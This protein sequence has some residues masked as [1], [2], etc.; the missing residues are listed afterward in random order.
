[1]LKNQYAILLFAISCLIFAADVHTKD[2]HVLN[3]PYSVE[4]TGSFHASYVG[5]DSGVSV[6]D[7]SGDF[8]KYISGQLNVDAR[9]VVATE[10][11]QNIEPDHHFLVFFT[12][13]AVDTADSTAFA[14][15]YQNTVEGI[16]KPIFNNSAAMGSDQL[17]TT[18]DMADVHRWEM[19]PALPR[20]DST[21]D[22]LVH[23]MMHQWGINVRFMNAQGQTSTDLLGR[24]G[25]HWNYFMHSNASVMYGAAWD[26]LNSNLF[27]TADRMRSLSPLDLYLMGMVQSSAVPDFFYIDSGAPG[28]VNDIP[29]IVGTEVTGNRINVSIQD[30]IAAEG[31]RIPSSDQSPHQFN[32]KFVLLKRPLEQL[33]AELTGQLLVLQREFQKRFA[34]ETGGKGAILYPQL[35]THPGPA[36]PESLNYELTTEDQIDLPLAIAF[37]AS[38]AELNGWADKP[39]TRTRDTALAVRALN[40]LGEIGLIAN[41]TNWLE[42]HTPVSNDELAWQLMS[43]VLSAGKQQSVV[44]QLLSNI[45]EDGGWGIKAGTESSVVDTLLV[46]KALKGALGAAYEPGSETLAFIA[47]Q[48][49]TD[50]A[51]G[52]AVG[53]ESTLIAS[54]LLLEMYYALTGDAIT[55]SEI[56]NQLINQQLPDGG[57]GHGVASVHHTAQA[58]AA[59]EAANDQSHSIVIDNARLKLS[60]MQSTDGSFE[61]SVYST[62]LAV[63]M[64]F[65]D[66]RPNISLV[67]LSTTA[68]TVVA[69]EELVLEVSLANAGADMAQGFS[70]EVWIDQATHSTVALDALAAGESVTAQLM[71]DTVTLT[72]DVILNVVADPGDLIVESNEADNNSS[73]SVQV[74]A[75]TQVPELAFLISQSSYRPDFVDRLPITF[76]AE[77]M[78]GNHSSSAV[79]DVVLGLYQQQADGSFTELDSI[80]AD[81][82]QSST[83]AFNFSTQITDAPNNT[84]LVL[85]WVIDPQNQIQEVNES[86]NQWQVILPQVPTVDLNLE[87]ADV[88]MPM[89]FVVGDQVEISFD[90]RNLGSVLSSGFSLKAELTDGQSTV[91]LYD[92]QILEMAGGQ[93]FTRQFNWI[94]D[95]PG[96][97]ELII[98][99]DDSDQVAEVD[100]TNNSVSL[101][102]TVVANTYSNLSISD[103]DVSI[104]PDPGLVGQL[105]TVSARVSNPSDQD[106][107]PYQLEFLQ[108]IEDNTTSLAVV[109]VPS[110][111]AGSDEVVNLDLPGYTGLG[112]VTF[113]V[114]ADPANLI[115]EFNEN[116]NIG[117]NTFRIL[118][119][120]DAMVSSGGFALQPTIPVIGEQLSVDV[121]VVN[122]GEQPLDD[123]S[124][125]LYTISNGVETEVAELTIPLIEAGQSQV[126]Q[127]S[128]V[129]PND[130]DLTALKVTTDGDD[131]IIEISE[132]NNEAVLQIENQSKVFYV[133]ETYFSPNGDGVK[134][135]TSIVFNLDETDDYQISIIDQFNETI[136]TFPLQSATQ[137]GDLIW[138]G[139]NDLNRL[140]LDGQ[141][142]VT[143]TGQN[144][145]TSHQ[146]SVWLDTNRT[147]LHESLIKND[148][149]V[150]D[151]ECAL[152]SVGIEG[153]VFFNLQYSAD[154]QSIYLKD[155]DYGDRKGKLYEVGADG[156]SAQLLTPPTFNDDRRVVD[157]H[158]LD[159]GHIIIDARVNIS[160][161]NE[162]WFLDP[163]SK[164]F[165]QLDTQ[166][167]FSFNIPIITNEYSVITT[168][169]NQFLKIFHDLSPGVSFSSINPFGS[170]LTQVKSGWLDRDEFD[171]FWFQDG[172]L[173]NSPV[174]LGERL[175]ARSNDSSRALMFSDG[176]MVLFQFAGGQVTEVNDIFESV[177]PG[178]NMAGY[179]SPFNQFISVHNDQ[180]SMFD[181]NG[182]K[183]FDIANPYGL[184]FLQSW[185]IE[186]YG[187]LDDIVVF[188]EIGE[189]TVSYN[190]LENIKPQFSRFNANWLSKTE[191]LLSF[192]VSYSASID[193]SLVGGMF[194]EFEFEGSWQY[195]RKINHTDISDVGF[196]ETN[197]SSID[198]NELDSHYYYSEQELLLKDQAYDA[199]E[200]N[201]QLFSDFE[202]IQAYPRNLYPGKVSSLLLATENENYRAECRDLNDNMVLST[203]FPKDN[204]FTQLIIEHTQ[205]GLAINGTVFDANLDHFQ[206]YY[207]ESIDPENWLL[208][209]GGSEE[210]FNQLLMNWNPPVSGTYRVKL[211][212]TDKAGNRTSVIKQTAVSRTQSIISVPTVDP[213]YISPNG[214]GIKEHTVIEYQSLLAG[215]VL[216]EVTNSAGAVV[217][218]WI[219]EYA[220]SGQ[221]EQLVWTGTDDNAQ[222]L[223]D[224][225]YLVSVNGYR[226]SVMIDTRPPVGSTQ[227]VRSPVYHLSEN[228]TLV[229]SEG[230]LSYIDELRGLPLDFDGFNDGSPLALFEPQKQSLAEWRAMG[231]YRFNISFDDYFDSRGVYRWQLTDS[232]GNTGFS[233]EVTELKKIFFSE[234]RKVDLR[235]AEPEV[236]YAPLHYWVLEERKAEK[237]SLDKEDDKPITDWSFGDKLSLVWQSFSDETV[238]SV[239]LIID[240]SDLNGDAISSERIIELADLATAQTYFTDDLISPDNFPIGSFGRPSLG[241]ELVLYLVEM[242][243]SW[244]EGFVGGISV[245]LEVEFAGTENSASESFSISFIESPPIP[246]FTRLPVPILA[247]ETWPES[248]REYYREVIE[249]LDLNNGR[250]YTLLHIPQ[251]LLTNG[252]RVDVYSYP[253]DEFLHS[254]SPFR[255]DSGEHISHI[256]ELDLECNEKVTAI[257]RAADSSVNELET[258]LENN[259]IFVSQQRFD[260]GAMCDRNQA[261]SDAVWV[262]L[263]VA[264]SNDPTQDPVSLKLYQYNNNTEPVLIYEEP[265][266]S[267]NFKVN[268]YGLRYYDSDIHISKQLFDA[269]IN[270]VFAEVDYLFDRTYSFSVPFDVSFQG[271]DFDIISPQSDVNYCGSTRELNSGST[272]TDV[273]LDLGLVINNPGQTGIFALNLRRFI[274]GV[275][276]DQE[277]MDSGL[278]DGPP[279][280]GQINSQ[281]MTLLY[282][283]SNDIKL[284]PFGGTFGFDPPQHQQHIELNLTSIEGPA[285]I[286]I[287]AINSSG[288][289]V[290]ESVQINIDTL[291]NVAVADQGINDYSPAVSGSVVFAEIEAYEDADIEIMLSDSQSLIKVMDQYSLSQ[292]QQAIVSWDGIVAG[293]IVEDGEY[294]IVVRS[295]DACGNYKLDRI[296][297]TVDTTPPA[298]GFLNLAD[299]QSIQVLQDV[300]VYLDELNVD[301]FEV[302][303]QYLDFWTQFEMGEVFNNGLGYQEFLT[304]WDLSGLPIGAYP[305]RI[306]ARDQ[307]G[308]E[309]ELQITLVLNEAQNLLWEFDVS[310]RLI[311]PNGDGIKDTTQ[312]SLGLNLNA[313]VEVLMVDENQAQV[314]E[315]FS[316]VLQDGLHEWTWDGKDQLSTTVQDGQYQLNVTITE[317]GN[318]SNSTTVESLL[319]VDA[320]APVISINPIEPVIKG[321]GQ[322]TIVIDDEH[323][324]EHSSQLHV[325]DS[326]ELPQPIPS[327]TDPGIHHQ[328]ALSDL[329][330][331]AYEVRTLA[332]DLAGNIIEHLH[333]LTID[334]TPP[335]LVLTEPGQD[336]VIGGLHSEFLISGTVNE[337]HFAQYQILIS[338]DVEPPVWQELATD[339]Q[340]DDG[341]FSWPWIFN[342]ADGSYLLKVIVTD[343]AGW[344]AE[345]INAFTLDR[346]PPVVALTSPADQLQVGEQLV[347][348]GTVDDMSLV[349][350][351]ISH[352]TLGSTE[353]TAIRSG[354]EPIINDEIF[355][356]DHQLSSGDHEFRILANDAAGLSTEIIQSFSVD[357]TPPGAPQNLVVELLMNR[358]AQLNWQPVDAVDLAGYQVFRNNT[359]LNEQ[360]LLNPQLTDSDLPEGQYSY[361]VVA[362]DDIGNH[363]VP[364]NVQ[365]II[366]DRTAPLTSIQTPADQSLVNGSVDIIGS[367]E[368][369]DDLAS[370]ELFIRSVSEPAPGQLLYTST[371]PVTAQLMSQLDTSSLIQDESYVILLRSTDLLNNI[372]ITEHTVTV[373]N[374]PPTAPINLV[375]TIQ[376]QADVRLDWQ[377]NQEADLSGYLVFRNG[378]IVSGNGTPESGQVTDVFYLDPAVA[379]G[380]YIYQVAAIDLA[381]NISA[382]SQQVE[383]VIS[384]RAPD[385]GIS[386]PSDG[387]RFGDVV[388]IQATSPDQDLAHIWIEYSINH[389][390]WFTISLD[391]V[392]PY[393]VVFSPNDFGLGYGT[394]AI[395]AT[396]E[397]TAAQADQTPAQINVEYTDVTSPEPLDNIMA[398]SAGSTVNL[399]W[400]ASNAADLLGYQVFRRQL[401]PVE[402]TDFVLLHV[403]LLTT[404][405]YLD[406]GLEVGLY[407]YQVLAVDDYDNA[408][409]PGYSNEAPVMAISLHQPYS[410]VLTPVELVFTGQSEYSGVIQSELSNASGDLPLTDVSV[411]LSGQFNVSTN[412]WQAGLNNLSAELVDADGHISLVA[413]AAIEVSEVPQIPDNPLSSVNGLELTL[414]WDAPTPDT[415]GYLLHLNN[416]P[417]TPAERVISYSTAAASS[418]EFSADYVFD[419][420]DTSVWSPYFDDVNDGNPSYLE[421][422]FDQP[423]W[424]LS[425]AFHWDEDYLFEGDVS[426]PSTYQLQYL[427]AIGWITQQDFTGNNNA[428]VTYVGDVPYLAYGVRLWMPLAANNFD[429][430]RL[431][432]WDIQHQPLVSTNTYVDN[433]SDGV[434]EWQV[435]AINSLGFASEFTALEQISLGDT[436]RPEPVQLTAQLGQ[437]VDADLSWTASSSLDVAN[438]RVFRNGALILST[439]DANTLS[440][441]DPAL[442]NGTYDYH[443]IAVD[444]V[445]NQSLSSNTEQV[446]VDQ[447]LLPAPGGLMLQRVNTGGALALSW[448]AYVHPEF[449][450]FRLYRSTQ[451]QTGYAL[452]TETTQL[453]FTD[454]GLDNGTTYHYYLVVIDPRGNESHPS[455]TVFGTPVDLV[456]P[457]QPVIKEPTVA[458]IPI[459]VQ[460][461]ITQIQGEGEPGLAI[462]LFH[463]QDFVET[464]YASDQY[465]LS[466][467]DL[468]IYL[469]QPQLNSANTLFAIMDYNIGYPAILNAETGARTDIE[470]FDVSRYFWSHDGETLYFVVGYGS[471]TAIQAFDQSGNMLSTLF[472]GYSID[473]LAISPDNRHLLY[474]GDGLNP[475]NSQVE[476]GVWLYDT[477]NQTHEK[478]EVNTSTE[479]NSEAIEWLSD[480]LVA[481][482]NYPNGSYD[483]GNLWTYELSTG[484][485]TQLDSST[486]PYGT[487]T[488]LRDGSHLYYEVDV[489]GYV[490]IK[491]LNRS[492]LSV[493]TMGLTNDELMMPTVSDDAN[494]V[495]ANLGCCDKVMLDLQSSEVLF[496]WPN[497]GYQAPSEWLND[498]RILFVENETGFLINGP[499]SFVFE[500]VELT[501]GLNEFFVVARKPNGL[502]TASDEIQVTL[503]TLSLPDLVIKDSYLQVLPDEVLSGQ[504]VSGSL[505][506]KNISSVDVDDARLLI[507]ITD[508][509]LNT[510][511]VSPA[512]LNIGLMAG[513]SFVTDFTIADL[514]EVGEYVIKSTIDSNGAVLES[515]ENNNSTYRLLQVIDDLKPDVTVVVNSHELFPGDQ[516][517][518]LITVY[519]PGAEFTGILELEITDQAGF[520]TGYYET[521]DL[522]AL[523]SG[524]HWNVTFDWPADVF[525]D[526]YQLHVTL[527]EGNSVVDAELIDLVVR[528]A[529]DFLLSLEASLNQALPGDRIILNA[530]LE[531]F[532]G[533]SIQDGT[534]LWQVMD[535]QD[536]VIWQHSEQIDG[537]APGLNIQLNQIWLA[538]DPGSYTAVLTWDNLLSFESV[539]LPLEVLN[540]VS[541]ARIQ[542]Q[543]SA[544]PTPVTLGQDFTTTA[545]LENTGQ[546]DLNQLNIEAR[547]MTQDLSAVLLTDQMSVSLPTGQTSQVQFNWSSDSLTLDHYI[548]VLSV[549]LSGFGESTQSTLDTLLIE[550][551]DASGPIITI[552]NPLHGGLYP[553]DTALITTVTDQHA[554]VN[555]VS[556]L[557][558][559]QLFADL[560][561]N[562]LSQVYQT[563]LSGLSEGVHLL[564]VRAQDEYGNASSTSIDF[565]VD[566]TP[567]LIQ[568]DGVQ[569]GGLYNHS[570]TPIITITD[571]NL[572]STTLMMNGLP[573]QSGQSLSA[574]GSYLLMVSATDLTGNQI[575]QR[576]SFNLDLTPPLLNISFPAEGSDTNLA[577]TSVTGQTEADVMVQLQAGTH[578]Q[579]VQAA[580]DGSYVFTDVPL[581][582]GANVLTL[583]AT[584]QAGNN[585]AEA[586]RTVNYIDAVSVTGSLTNADSHPIGQI[587]TIDWQVNNPYGFAIDQLAVELRLVRV[588]DDVVSYTRSQLIDLPAN[589]VFND[590]DNIQT[591]DLLPGAYQ[592][593]LRV[594]V[595]QTEELIGNS[596]IQLED[597]TGPLLQVLTPQDGAV[598]AAELLLSATASD[599]SSEVLD[600]SYQ[601]DGVG[602]WVSMNLLGIEYT[603]D[604]SL[605]H[606]Q[607]AIQFRAEDSF[608]NQTFSAVINVTIDDQPPLITVNSPA[609]GL[610]TN[611]DVSIDYVMVDDLG[612]TD[613][614]VLNGLPVTS[615][616]VVSDEGDHVLTVRGT[617]DVGNQA[618]HVVQF[619]IDLTPPDLLVDSPVNNQQVFDPLID[620]TGSAEPRNQI[621]T[622]VNGQTGSVNTDAAGQFVSANHT[623][624][625]GLNNITVQAEDEAGNLSQLVV[626]V[627]EYVPVGQVDGSIWHDLNQNGLF[628]AGESGIELAEVTLTDSQQASQVVYTNAS[629]LFSYADVQPGTYTI[630]V[631]D[632]ELNTDWISSTMNS[633]SAITVTAGQTESIEFGYYQQAPV[634]DTALTAHDQDGR[635]L[636]LADEPMAQLDG[637]CQGVTSFKMMRH[638]N[639]LWQPGDQLIVELYDAQSNLIQ[640][641]SG[642]YADFLAN[643]Q[644]AIDAQ[645]AVSLVNLILHPMNSGQISAT[646]VGDDEQA[647]DLLNDDYQLLMK[648]QT[649]SGLHQWSSNVLITNCALF[650]VIGQDMG[651]LKVANVDL[652]PAISSDEPGDVTSPVLLA[653]YTQL[654]GLLD[655]AGWSYELVY[656]EAD[657]D[658]AMLTGMFNTY[659]LMAE[660]VPLGN[661]IQNQLIN[662]LRA[663]SG[664]IVSSGVDNL[665]PG[666]YSELGISVN[667]LYVNVEGLQLLNSELAAATTTELDPQD[668]ALRVTSMGAASA[669]ILLGS[670]IVN[671][672]DQAVTWTQAVNGLAV[673]AAFDWLLQA[674]VEPDANHFAALINQVVRF[675]QPWGLSTELGGTRRVRYSLFNQGRAVDGHVRVT[676]PPSVQLMHATVPTTQETDGFSFNYQ[677]TEQARLDFE[678]WLQVSDSPVDVTFEVYAQGLPDIV[679]SQ[680]MTLIA[681]QK[682]DLTAEISNCQGLVKP[683]ADMSYQLTIQN[684]GNVDISQASAIT[685]FN[686]VSALTWTCES[687]D[688]AHC[689]SA[690]GTGDLAGELIDL[691]VGST[692]TY[693]LSG[694]VND[695]TGQSA[696]ASAV[697]SMPAEWGDVTPENNTASDWDEILPFLFNDGFECVAPTNGQQ[698][699][700]MIREIL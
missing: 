282:N 32:F 390:D 138:D 517:Y 301:V 60:G 206:L 452:V 171:E 273:H 580:A 161:L 557:L 377:A 207:A 610:I 361:W 290:C 570:V 559:G 427:S 297:F 326:G 324:A 611:Q 29:S 662:E 279:E 623:L 7:F 630:A 668:S 330:E 333:N 472:S 200:S 42:Q 652:Y 393:E 250:I 212:A 255:D 463:N 8:D 594:T 221:V 505:L 349:H 172:Q 329:A 85:K 247:Q 211:V 128:F 179:F 30:I 565:T 496:S 639:H 91:V 263:R 395:R 28:D 344:Q 264:L 616:A 274:N 229:G 103:E 311:S 126:A 144:S 469:E 528:E 258:R 145:G 48:I 339:S 650:N 376:N 95:Q 213:I 537:L 52:Y 378:V 369:T 93:T 577:S 654:R 363:S 460:Q 612:V 5:E 532:W 380:T 626:L 185:V 18:I 54:A 515:N 308:N 16:G 277:M 44:D 223:P 398:Q 453:N 232:A 646:V 406:Q 520:P 243:K 503:D 64:L 478:V 661:S 182:I 114:Q 268:E 388:R 149:F 619:R 94:P 487:L 267:I 534:L 384:R 266:M 286:E 470:L 414:N 317:S 510:T 649:S 643:G 483:Y 291:V 462:D 298:V 57:F 525:A 321:E 186:T 183:L 189:F 682:P 334:N 360:L 40:N 102:F 325:P 484:Q 479:L 524:A 355:I 423:Q 254:L 261:N 399:S 447:Q 555:S 20:F 556:V 122:L 696:Q 631:T 521:H 350:Y 288:V 647:N 690:S 475:D 680:S 31:I 55:E 562:T 614:S 660:Q 468:G 609:D 271:V 465:V 436:T 111:A 422:T 199:V 615:G 168:S 602:G 238:T 415:F 490:A 76:E 262:N 215:E 605:P 113:I 698:V 648:L 62:A 148:G 280:Y 155:K 112:D 590:V 45:N 140:A 480:D 92:H 457:A 245:G 370:L 340:L 538:A 190:D 595:D 455:V 302:S 519:N 165:Y 63:L 685:G 150:I 295:E 622:V 210:R 226:Y 184:D 441:V 242:D 158:V 634:I 433:L 36:H 608:A 312:I 289:S 535:D 389:T 37:L 405:D 61:G 347:F 482:I 382:M 318:N 11:Y 6:I 167:E 336:A 527:R 672:E 573:Y 176:S 597:V 12:T 687:L 497:I 683:G 23:E 392:A 118:N 260:L 656:S 435:A 416:Q 637:Q 135:N 348:A 177:N 218:S 458:G 394:I 69:G 421:F 9:Q 310:E 471:D 374:V 120:P 371:I 46:L 335:L 539:Q 65:E 328:L 203:Y 142:L 391:T 101:P 305:V 89:Q 134:D 664:L 362:V 99:L 621:N 568:I 214:D 466:Q 584:D 569:D 191:L 403:D 493:V 283:D 606:G 14:I 77:V 400:Q 22:T 424:I 500:Q 501:P 431:R 691:P 667:G 96:N 270:Q 459:H 492:D 74:N 561:G 256:Y 121:S 59:L 175:I 430:I 695:A 323:L 599:H 477:D 563:P 163:D 174:R 130:P 485:L 464:V 530:G 320:T 294:A 314:T 259:C 379:D 84:D 241:Q 410:P 139:R 418:D 1:M 354:F 699:N 216:I 230:L 408:S 402:E 432:E 551:Q 237:K 426:M 439:S 564:E 235:H 476:F 671:G 548:L 511:M 450:A 234:L 72:G 83:F 604:I 132:L 625:P 445:G 669:A 442:P 131:Q 316:G 542:G 4:G 364:S 598:S 225:E 516:L 108:Q 292:G 100:E 401:L 227:L 147:T 252:S 579:L 473:E 244:F 367:V 489:D 151:L 502:E 543:W 697:I 675:V 345:Q 309:S 409:E 375:Y 620:I 202:L 181:S 231:S 507:E 281:R 319:K 240:G 236:V 617:D 43:D 456:P 197:Y 663:G 110:L 285:T 2:F 467:T 187:S 98:S 651:E 341:A 437:G 228:S 582:E 677:L 545:V 589:G 19:N 332:G 201:N 115:A 107:G 180:L 34:A 164:V 300:L 451:A 659:W 166:G 220:Q 684:T 558:D 434:Y 509:Q 583:Q 653:Q 353:W 39:A 518:G 636:I 284:S 686:N 49:N 13:F 444:Q 10:L 603:A 491:R 429:E 79:T 194:E 253:G 159:N 239:K 413:Q 78:I 665:I 420:D 670:E 296:N 673:F 116:D 26:Q 90:F 522:I 692:V 443:V 571:A 461:S 618:E 249:H 425:S 35:T 547:L 693:Q 446:V 188:T 448:D 153:Q 560:P 657:F 313:Q 162:L 552:Q 337:L 141:Y 546:V 293:Q 481:F 387:H 645:P 251:R 513:E 566:S 169:G 486:A 655:Q 275:D 233:N 540:P 97:F 428:V 156:Q 224:G 526:Q 327:A 488:A 372:H 170:S 531:Y 381:G 198:L 119:L 385:T 383:V 299:G 596:A 591:D 508:P 351:Q 278:F 88:V 125:T 601:L 307:F 575:Q 499:G 219:R 638:T 592:A 152:Q 265:N 357:A 633:P 75:Q 193:P 504:P 27:E 541:Q 624:Q 157:Y 641:E 343:E 494:L 678:F 3:T 407:Q 365:T 600:V 635:I 495:F 38:N 50:S 689:A 366:V 593:H 47:Q 658:A 694:V 58:L 209:G 106:S 15:S 146:T 25:V 137:F 257:W 82:N 196:Y 572:A 536:Q 192:D 676:L 411:D 105:L 117:F 104:S 67:E 204:L 404:T 628:D 178:D 53:G 359:L 287:E 368:E 419:E 585:S 222:V 629:G 195:R 129:F 352:R 588:S 87:P 133:T 70:L 544:Q 304:N 56:I 666:L 68:S 587:L 642:S 550:T 73:L 373:D 272:M 553:A 33:N 454:V 173:Q 613:Q 208:L 17:L 346:A 24:D 51:T 396:A 123:V 80:S 315:V 342:R 306:F 632:S 554:D 358:D 574:E 41:G 417:V 679:D 523:S 440:Y 412:L 246:I 700:A 533:N 109:D 21:L 66:Q 217:R 449:V 681:G 514:S 127:F 269:G 86:N 386:A 438:Y 248:A 688:G 205:L 154:G 160:N 276:L 674:T 607:H 549:D 578:Q 581:V 356:W 331:Q 136:R 567:P 338:E 124:A 303:Y 71:V 627:V 498:G 397:D 143:I 529:A 640:T 506:V 576:L 322:L 81:I 474:W 512:P 586:S 644:L